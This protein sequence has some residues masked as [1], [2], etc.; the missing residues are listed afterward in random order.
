[1]NRF[2][3]H[4]LSAAVLTV[5]AG[6]AIPA[7]AHDDASIFVTGVLY[8]PT[9]NGQSCT[10]SA[11]PTAPLLSRGLVDG[12][13]TDNYSPEFLVGSTLVPKG[14]PSI[15][16]SETA[17]VEIQGTLIKVV[18]PV[19]NSVWENNT[20]LTSGD[21]PARLGNG[22]GLQRDRGEHHGRQG[23]RSLHAGPQ[24]RDEARRRLRHLLRTD[25]RRAERPEQR[26]PVSGG[27]LLRVPRLHP[28]VGDAR[29]GGILR[30]ARVLGEHDERVRAVPGRIR[31]R[32][33]SS[34]TG[35]RNSAEILVPIRRIRSPA[36][37]PEARAHWRSSTVATAARADPQVSSALLTVGGGVVSEGD[38][39]VGAFHL[40][41]RGDV[42][43]LRRRDREMGLGPFVAVGSEAFRSVS[44]EG[45]IDW[46]VPAWVDFPFVFAAGAFDRFDGSP[47][48]RGRSPGRGVVGISRV[49]LREPLR[50][51]LQLVRGGALR[52][53][54]RYGAGRSG[55]GRN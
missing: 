1:M 46:L 24:R 39:T 51:V 20:V 53:G 14:N 42:L 44:F 50:P 8:P 54:L 55:G 26:V 2:W 16:N 19:D 45:G 36:R 25:A 15:P 23:D 48:S 7:C 35:T 33:A 47:G 22:A 21:P 3:G 32:I 11:D 41:A 13:V 43:F 31:P 49:R 29:A 37:L 40:G 10:Y 38:R 5:V 18:D 27:R 4:T 17:R 12:A 6:I 52:A 30:R 28:G 9:P 34:A